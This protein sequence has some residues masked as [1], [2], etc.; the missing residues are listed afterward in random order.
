MLV[1][2]NHCGRK[3][4]YGDRWSPM[5]KQDIWRRVLNKLGISKRTEVRRE[6]IFSVLYNLLKAAKGQEAKTLGKIINRPEFHTYI[7]SDC[8]EKALGRKLTLSDITDCPFNENFKK[9]YFQ[10]V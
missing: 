7:C 9:E 3:F 5:L 1:E 4:H 2:C 8:M 10:Q 6:Y